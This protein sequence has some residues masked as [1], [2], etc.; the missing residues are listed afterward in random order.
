MT[1][2]PSS[3]HSLHLWLCILQLH[4]Y[5]AFSIIQS[6]H[7]AYL[8]I[9]QRWDPGLDPLYYKNIKLIT[10]IT[11]CFERAFMVSIS[12]MHCSCRTRGT[13]LWTVH[14]GWESSKQ[15][16]IMYIFQLSFPSVLRCTRW[17]IRTMKITAK[18][19]I[20]DESEESWGWI[21]SKHVFMRLERTLTQ[22]PKHWLLCQRTQAWVPVLEWQL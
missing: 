21:G 13:I 11:C 6:N 17:K 16:I 14:S 3:V 19:E 18:G 15:R 1:L 20:R 22:W 7:V 12:T 4:M 8:S 10:T 9:L 2:Q 5:C